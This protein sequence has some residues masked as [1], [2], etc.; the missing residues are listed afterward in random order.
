MADPKKA[1]DGPTPFTPQAFDKTLIPDWD[2]DFIV[3]E[4]IE[5]FANALSQPDT[6]APSEEDLLHP[7]RQPTEFITALNDWKP[8]HQKVKGRPRTKSSRLGKKRKRAPRR[9][10]DETRE[11]WTYTVLK[12]P[13][14]L[15]VCA[16]I[17]GLGLLYLLTRLYIYFYERIITLR[18]RRQRL[19]HK[20]R[21]TTNYQDWIAAANDLDRFLKGD[22]WKTTDDYAYYDSSII[23]RVLDHLRQLRASVESDRHTTHNHDDAHAARSI[24][25]MRDTLQACVKNNFAGFEN[26]LLYSE[27]YYG[28]KTLVQE[29]VDE[30]STCLQLVFDSP[31]L[32]QEDKRALAKSLSRNFGTTALCLSGGATFA[33]YHLGLVKALLDADLLPQTITG[34]SGGALVAA[35]VGTRTNDEL[36]QILV[37]ALAARITACEESLMTGIR[38]WYKTGARFDSLDWAKKAAWFTHGSMTFAEAFERTGRSVSV[39]CVPSD[40]HTPSMLLNHITAPDCV[41]WSATLASAA[42]PGIVNP[43]VLMAKG[44][45]GNLKPY[46]FGKWRDGSLRTDIPIKSLNLF[47]NTNFTI[48]SQVN[49]HVN[50]FFFA[51][52]GSVGRPVTHRKGRGWRGGFLGSA[53]EQYLKLD[54]LKWLK[55]L[56][57][58]ELLPRTAGADWSNVWLQ[59]FS[60][61]IT[62]WPKVRLSDFWYI[63]S[64]PTP[65]R[66]ARMIFSGQHAA[67]PKLHFISNRMKIERVIEDARRVTRDPHALP[68]PAID[69]AGLKDMFSERDL[70]NLLSDFKRFDAPP[71][72]SLSAPP[73]LRKTRSAGSDSP[74]S[75]PLDHNGTNGDTPSLKKKFSGWLSSLSGDSS[76]VTDHD[77]KPLAGPGRRAS[78]LQELRDQA[79]IFSS[80]DSDLGE[81]EGE[82]S[83]DGHDMES[84]GDVSEDCVREKAAVP[85]TVSFDDHVVE[86]RA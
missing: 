83:V 77:T 57:H 64:D 28:T 3:D 53:L 5:A 39:S 35:L 76:P 26:P 61:T 58:L 56:R 11:G 2:N 67:F 34:T 38:R 68:T 19:K 48:V 60:G 85:R 82:E 75:Q 65:E 51:S 20:M 41:I 12:W 29:F 1:T 33:F 86:H 14:F 70:R 50:V 25:D 49:P 13:L 84:L 36:K 22:K 72:H 23:R 66:L 54:L 78:V 37:P 43:V 42:V 17:I 71:N 8:V 47:F 40:P 45:D 62:I 24:D 7:S 63:L 27:T 10:K 44:R 21:T 69:K 79:H 52:R 81:T 55:I 80:D 30:V 15:V 46:T 6:A 4:D 16:W 32:S 59:K 73:T 74:C 18:G 31:R 9:G